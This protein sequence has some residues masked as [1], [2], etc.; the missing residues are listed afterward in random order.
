MLQVHLRDLHAA[1]T[2]QG[3]LGSGWLLHPCLWAIIP[4][5]T[6]NL[7]LHFGCTCIFHLYHCNT[8]NGYS[9]HFSI[10]SSSP[11]FLFLYFYDLAV[12]PLKPQSSKRLQRLLTFQPATARLW[13]MR[14]IRQTKAQG[15]GLWP[16]CLLFL[17]DSVQ[18]LQLFQVTSVFQ[19]S[20]CITKY[21]LT[22][23]YNCSPRT[24][25]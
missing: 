10:L 19:D 4:F 6:M 16:V 13:P 22:F 9:D 12:L 17:A 23:L 8:V 2:L 24:A 18:R 15:K 21:S 3:S 11:L 14:W 5:H 1:S 25:G 7:W 20:V